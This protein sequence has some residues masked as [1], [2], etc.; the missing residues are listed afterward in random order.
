MIAAP[1][2]RSPNNKGQFNGIRNEK[3]VYKYV[4]IMYIAEKSHKYQSLRL[5]LIDTMYI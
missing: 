4:Y 5:R 2:D 1:K 3:H